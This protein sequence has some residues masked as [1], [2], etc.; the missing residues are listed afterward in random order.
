[1]AQQVHLFWYNRRAAQG[2]GDGMLITWQLPRSLRSE[3]YR[4][5]V[6][7]ETLDLTDFPKLGTCWWASKCASYRILAPWNRVT[8][9]LMRL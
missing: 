9:V 4:Q 1:M 2:S 3:M 6:R 5:V 7:S 8:S